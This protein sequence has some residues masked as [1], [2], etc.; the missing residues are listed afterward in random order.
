M[1][2]RGGGR[3]GRECEKQKESWCIVD[4]RWYSFDDPDQVVI[5]ARGAF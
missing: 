5:V 4:G 2:R 3:K 1:K